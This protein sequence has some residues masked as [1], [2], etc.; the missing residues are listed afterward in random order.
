MSVMLS[1]LSGS[2]TLEASFDAVVTETHTRSASVTTHPVE[3]GAD[4]A[5]HVNTNPVTLSLEAIVTNTPL[6]TPATMNR[7]ARGEVS[8]VEGTKANALQ[9]D[10][11][12]DRP[13]DV[14]DA[15]SE[16]FDKGAV[17]TVDTALRRYEDMVIIDLTVPREAGSGLDTQ[18]GTRVDKLSF[19]LS[20]QQVRVVGSREGSV[21]RTEAAPK[22]KE[23][24]GDKPKKEANDLES[25]AHVLLYGGG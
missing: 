9:F 10:A 14:Y 13:K 15:I 1:W 11:S 20:M 8:A 25:S 2:Q 24:K 16:A 23:Q 22:K 17:F 3:Q 6:R 7:N 18:S 19:T 5:D 4:V 21:R 12:M